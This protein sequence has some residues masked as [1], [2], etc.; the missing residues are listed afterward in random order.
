MKPIKFKTD[1]NESHKYAIIEIPEG[2]DRV[3][4]FTLTGVRNNCDLTVFTS[5]YDLT[6]GTMIRIDKDA[7]EDGRLAYIQE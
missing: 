2:Y 5:S 3:I 4:S 1:S 7:L 6:K